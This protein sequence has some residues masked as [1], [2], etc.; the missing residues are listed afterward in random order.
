MKELTLLLCLVLSY[1]LYTL[2]IRKYI[3]LTKVKAKDGRSYL[4]RQIKDNQQAAE[5]LSQLSNKLRRLCDECLQNPKDT[6]KHEYIKTLSEKF[7]AKHITENIPGSSHVAYSVNKGDELSICIREK[8]TEKFLDMNTIVFVSIHELAHIMTPEM[9]HTPLFWDNMRYLL[10]RA[11]DIDI[12]TA[13]DYSKTPIM[14]CGIE[15]N[16]TPLNLRQ[17]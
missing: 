1:V 10:E 3:F 12:Y 6:S 2:Y 16:S 13:V 11:I 8:D 15:I 4:V 5:I 14:Y 7:N 17:K 9:G